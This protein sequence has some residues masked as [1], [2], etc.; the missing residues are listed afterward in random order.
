MGLCPNALYLPSC[1]TGINCYALLHLI[2]SHDTPLTIAKRILLEDEQPAPFFVLE[3]A[4]GNNIV[5]L[6]FI[7]E[8]QEDKIMHLT[9]LGYTAGKDAKISK[10]SKV[11]FA[12]EA[13]M[14]KV[15]AKDYADNS[16]TL[17]SQDPS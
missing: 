14:N 6:D 8:F 15:D 2:M 7:P 12:S 16:Y 17:P 5:Q 4:K 11:S 13:W 10:V 1:K 9:N 3:T